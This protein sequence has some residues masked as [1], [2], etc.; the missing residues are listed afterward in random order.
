M[1]VSN[2]RPYS[3]LVNAKNRL[4]EKNVV[5]TGLTAFG[6]MLIAYTL[7]TTTVLAAVTAMFGFN[8]TLWGSAILFSICTLGFLA[9]WWQ[10]ERQL[11][12]VA[13][14]NDPIVA[15]SALVAAPAADPSG[16]LNPSSIPRHSKPYMHRERLR[17]LIE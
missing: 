4:K 5:K 17:S 15:R 11:A 7:A 3:S 16:Q 9:L 14:S 10:E 6:Q 8:A 2:V 12:R 1:T 13:G